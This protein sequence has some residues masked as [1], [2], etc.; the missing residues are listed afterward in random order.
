M[1]INLSALRGSSEM[2]ERFQMRF[3]QI[4]LAFTLVELLVVMAIIGILVA[5]LLPAIQAAREASR[6][7]KCLN[8]LHQMAIG[9][10]EFHDAYGYFPPAFLK[11]NNWGWG[12]WILPFVEETNLFQSLNPNATP[13]S[14]SSDTTTP[15]QVFTCSSDPS[16]PLHIFYSN[17]AKSDYAVSEQVSDGSS[18]IRLKQI[19][20]GT[21]KTLMI[22]ERDMENQAGA[23][24][25]GRETTS[26]VASVIGRPTWLLNTKYAGGAT[27]CTT[28]TLCTRFAWSSLHPGGVNFALCDGSSRFFPETIESDPTQQTCNKPIVANFVLQNLYFRNDNNS[29]DMSAF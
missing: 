8:N 20:D 19:T 25:A 17:Y 18:K 6:R 29:V 27:C 22:G 21:S 3:N 12:V 5:L 4:R 14:V 11:P 26:G 9:M 2:Q 28:D 7:T 15:I 13:I 24:W 1:Y 16:P 10:H 23:I